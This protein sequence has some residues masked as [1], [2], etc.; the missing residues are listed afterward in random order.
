MPGRVLGSGEVFA[1]EC[2]GR[3]MGD[4]R[5]SWADSLDAVSREFRDTLSDLRRRETRILR[6]LWAA[7]GVLGVAGALLLGGMWWSS[8]E[9]GTSRSGP[10]TSLL[11]PGP[12]PLPTAPPLGF[13]IASPPS[14][15]PP[16]AASPAAPPPAAVDTAT[17]VAGPGRP[18][19]AP[20][21]AV[22]VTPVS[23]PVQG[24]PAAPPPDVLD[25]VDQTVESVV[26]LLASAL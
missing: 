19:S 21:R 3:G 8:L 20:V 25:S 16:P 10:P 11:S 7:T 2:G 5:P 13:G 26:H 14:A 6:F 24:A 18:V 23:G 4:Q 17:Q 12:S 9:T 22:P 1:V 15:P